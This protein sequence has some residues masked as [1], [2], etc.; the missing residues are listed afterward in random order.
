MPHPATTS[1]PPATAAGPQCGAGQDAAPRPQT[2]AQV[3]PTRLLDCTLGAHYDYKFVD[4]TAGRN[5]YENS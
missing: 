2:K 3:P 1:L 4:C 5:A